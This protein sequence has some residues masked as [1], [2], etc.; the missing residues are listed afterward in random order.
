MSPGLLAY[1]YNVLMSLESNCIILTQHDNDTYPLLMLQDVKN[2]RPDVT[3]I[4]IDM[5]IVKSYRDKIFHEY[6][7]APLDT[8][9]E[10]SNSVN[11]EVLLNHILK[12]YNNIRPLYLGLTITQKYYEKYLKSLFVTGLA[13][14][15]SHLP[16]DTFSIC[17]RHY[18]NFKLDYIGIQYTNDQNQNNVNRQDI[19]YLQSIKILYQVYRTKYID[20]SMK[21]KELA[22]LIADNSGDETLR[23]KIKEELR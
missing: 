18:S 23:N 16:I 20:K 13:L 17:E 19:N 15:Y 4:N 9:F 11:H 7:I 21:L 22:L 14:K 8:L 6:D 12:N 1:G 2:I 10:K 3:V 5:L